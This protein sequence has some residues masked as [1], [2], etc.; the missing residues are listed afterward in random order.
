MRIKHVRLVNYKRFTAL[1]IGEIPKSARLVVLVGPNGSG[2]SSVFD[3]FLLKSQ[4][5]MSNWNLQGERG[6]YYEKEIAGD[7]AHRTTQQ[8]AM[9][10]TV[11]F[12]SA[13][14]TSV[15]MQRAFCIRTAYRN[16]ADFRVETLQRLGPASERS[17][18]IRIVDSDVAVSENYARM[19]WKRMSDLDRDA[20]RATTIGQ[21]RDESLRE[22]QSEMRR[23]FTAPSLELQDFGGIEQAGAFRFAKAGVPDFHYKNLSGGEKAAFDLLL[24]L[25]VKRA[26]Y[27]DAVYCID[28]PESHIATQLHGT[29]LDAIL[30][31]LPVTSQLWIATHSAGFVRKAYE[32]FNADGDVVF[33]DFSARDFDRQVTMKPRVPDASFWKMTYRV[34][35]DD[36]ADLIAAQN[37]VL[38]EGRQEGDDPGFDAQCYMS[39]F[40]DTHAD[41]L[42]VG[43]GGSKDVRNSENLMAILASVAEGVIVWR[44]TDRDEM[45]VGERDTAIEGGIQVLG[46]REIENYLY[47]S[48]VLRSFLRKHGKEGLADDLIEQVEKLVPADV[49]RTVDVKKHSR[50]IFELIRKATSLPNLGNSREAFALEH[51]AP[52]LKKTPEVFRE[53][54]QDVFPSTPVAGTRDHS[55]L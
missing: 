31:L 24:D 47:D 28:E 27:P 46:R 11:D 54:E 5:E 38:C 6:E 37:I 20:P 7:A 18:F 35:L 42:F 45:S 3:A 25:F 15:D 53:L 36:L 16:E 26:E 2:K 50:K 40:A 39:V 29:L 32:R 52:A 51:L 48:A 9:N 14:G 30:K 8:I 44:L 55:G 19:I 22:L 23:L 43:R 17:R 13:S 33:L 12:H 49:R 34:A 41:T 1:D 4:A 10:V 21:Y